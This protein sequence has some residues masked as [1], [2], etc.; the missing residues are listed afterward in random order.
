LNTSLEATNT[1]S[2]KI[3][4]MCDV[5]AES[6]EEKQARLQ[7]Q[8]D[9]LNAALETLNGQASLLQVAATTKRASLRGVVA[10]RMGCH[11]MACR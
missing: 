3:D 11:G 4:T 5:P 1:Y 9:G 7:D 8:K 10:H 2:D 6:Y